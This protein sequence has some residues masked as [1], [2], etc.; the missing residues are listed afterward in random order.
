[1][2][3]SIY[4][5][6]TLYLIKM[7]FIGKHTPKYLSMCRIIPIKSI[8]TRLLEWTAYQGIFEVDSYSPT[9]SSGF[10]QAS[11]SSAVR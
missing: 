3:S 9:I 7:H 1:L 4:K 11:N 2:G 8:K 6:I 5:K 10:T